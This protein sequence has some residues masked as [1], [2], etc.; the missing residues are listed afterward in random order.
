[1]YKISEK[2]RTHFFSAL[3]GLRI[4][5]DDKMNISFALKVRKRNVVGSFLRAREK[6]DKKREEAKTS[7]CIKSREN[8]L[9]LFFVRVNKTENQEEDP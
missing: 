1:M 4:Q 8:V 3:T 9:R 5:K 7:F 2:S 6:I